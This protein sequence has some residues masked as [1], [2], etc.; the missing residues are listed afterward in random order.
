[1]FDPK[2]LDDLATRLSNLLPAGAVEFQR[3]MEKN[4]R[5]ALSAALAR[6]DLVTREEFEV[7]KALL[8]RTQDRV[9]ALESQMASLLA[10][11]TDE[12]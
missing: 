1:M 12:S 10:Q 2:I 8:E 11:G 4:L 7:Q 5:A 9:T 6:F 3:D